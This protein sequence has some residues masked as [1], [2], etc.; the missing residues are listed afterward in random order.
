MVL[1]KAISEVDKRISSA[2]IASLLHLYNIRMFPIDAT[3]NKVNKKVLKEMRELY[4]NI[5]FN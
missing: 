1:I 3:K 2:R 5:D 4:G